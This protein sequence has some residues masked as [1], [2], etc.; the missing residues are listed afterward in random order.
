MGS[1]MCLTVIMQ[2]S[3][4]AFQLECL[5]QMLCFYTKGVKPHQNSN[6]VITFTCCSWFLPLVPLPTVVS[7]LKSPRWGFDK[8]LDSAYKTSFMPRY[9][10]PRT[11][12]QQYYR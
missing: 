9:K 11:S 1:K 12:E 3:A 7:C 8:Q 2:G 6:C 10:S 4:V 5:I